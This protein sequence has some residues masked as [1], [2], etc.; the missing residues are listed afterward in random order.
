MIRIAVAQIG[1]VVE[2]GSCALDQHS[3]CCAETP[4]ASRDEPYMC[5]LLAT[6]ARLPCIDSDDCCLLLDLLC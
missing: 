3:A 1:G 6:A 5:Q 2:I 4:A